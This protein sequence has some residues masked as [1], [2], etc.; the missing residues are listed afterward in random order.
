[1]LGYY[2]PNQPQPPPWNLGKP[3]PFILYV[4]PKPSLTYSEDFDI[5]SL[6]LA[7]AAQALE[8]QHGDN[9]TDVSNNMYLYTGMF[10]FICFKY[11]YIYI[12]TYICFNN[13]YVMR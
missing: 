7:Q 11:A 12:F 13:I 2:S 4:A 10:N 9:R 8:V 3:S 5:P 1:M 6:T